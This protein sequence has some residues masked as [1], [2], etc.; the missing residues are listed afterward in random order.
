MD[1]KYNTPQIQLATQRLKQFL[2]QFEKMTEEQKKILIE[3][4]DASNPGMLA[5]LYNALN[6]YME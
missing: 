6:E 2:K 1:S 3:H 5:E 4:V